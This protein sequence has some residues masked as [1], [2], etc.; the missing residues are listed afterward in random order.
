ML[1]VN[2]I[3]TKEAFIVYY[4][5][6][7]GIL[8]SLQGQY[9]TDYFSSDQSADRLPSYFL[10]NSRLI[11]NLSKHFEIVL[12][13]NNILDSDYLIFGE[14]PGFSSGAYQMPGR[15]IQVGI[16]FKE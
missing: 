5:V 9:I 7:K 3:D 10:I 2:S 11:F 12:D 4:F 13:V 6:K 8:F 15:N 14:F 16:R 1:Q